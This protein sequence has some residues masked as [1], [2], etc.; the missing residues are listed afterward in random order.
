MPKGYD[1]IL[2]EHKDANEWISENP[3]NFV[4]A[5]SNNVDTI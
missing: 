4:L 2:L 1:P 5:K 3:D